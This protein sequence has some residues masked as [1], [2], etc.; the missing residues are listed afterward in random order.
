MNDERI[1]NHRGTLRVLTGALVTAGTLGLAMAPAS[2][3]GTTARFDQGVLTVTG[4]ALAD[5]IVVSRNA[6]GAILVNGGAVPVTGGTPTVANT[7]RITVLGQGANDV[8]TLSETNGALP[9]ADLF[10]GAGGDTLT[11]GSGND[12][13]F[14]Q[15]GNDTLLGKG[16]TDRLFGGAD[17]DVLTGGDADDQAHGEGGDDRFNWNP[18]DDTDLNEGG[19]GTDTVTVQGGNGAEQF[20]ASPNAGRVRFDRLNPAPFSID[21]GTSEKV[22]LSANG[23]DDTFTGN[24]GLAALVA[25]TV[26]GGAGNDLILG[27]DGADVLLGGDG[28]DV[29]DGGRGNDT[30]LLGAGD[31][32]F[33]WIRARAT[34][35][36]RGRTAP[37]P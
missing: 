29:V 22:V 28:N 14:G 18:G 9:R 20:L 31:D 19:T 33:R 32:T 1:T 26:D 2:A 4:T 17:N 12:G 27:G 16:G 37:T 35:P 13:L 15:A 36:S 8:V 34:T 3:V 21:I 5:S 7:A 6:A 10:G 25:V 30:G 11:S 24:S 23:G